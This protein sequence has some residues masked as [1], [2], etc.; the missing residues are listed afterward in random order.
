MLCPSSSVDQQNKDGS[1]LQRSSFKARKQS[2][3]V[4][5]PSYPSPNPPRGFASVCCISLLFFDL[6]LITG[7]FSTLQAAETVLQGRQAVENILRGD[8]DRLVVIVG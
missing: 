5:S 4:D 2:R 7:I 8:D 6:V 1:F 3:Q